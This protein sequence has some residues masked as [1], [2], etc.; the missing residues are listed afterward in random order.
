MMEKFYIGWQA[1]QRSNKFEGESLEFWA[2]KREIK[3]LTLFL[4][5]E[6]S[7]TSCFSSGGNFR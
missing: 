2:N 3:S 6:E 7:K 5:L 1:Y 4:M